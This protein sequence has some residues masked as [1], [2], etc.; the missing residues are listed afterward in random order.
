MSAANPRAKET[1]YEDTIVEAAIAAGWLVHA[2]RASRSSK[3]HRTAIKGIVGYPDL[4][5]VGYGRLI[6]IELKRKPNTPTPAQVRWIGEMQRAGIDARLTYVP[7]ELTALL[8]ELAARGKAREVCAICTG[9]HHS[10]LHLDD[11]E[12]R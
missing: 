9:P 11:V 7:E 6:V 3:G 12:A 5:I 4:T 1:E 10:R 2:E 8:R